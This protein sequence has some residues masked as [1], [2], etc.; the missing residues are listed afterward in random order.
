MMAVALLR[1]DGRVNDWQSLGGFLAALS[2]DGVK[3]VRYRTDQ[4]QIEV[5]LEKAAGI[6]A[7]VADATAKSGSALCVSTSLVP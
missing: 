1:G 5:D 4:L 2:G 7:S 6:F 3:S